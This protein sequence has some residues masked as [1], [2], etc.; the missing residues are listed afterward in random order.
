[1]AK[2][3]HCHKDNAKSRSSSGG[4]PYECNKCFKNRLKLGSKFKPPRL[5]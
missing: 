3:R 5:K 1:M 4:K 2:C